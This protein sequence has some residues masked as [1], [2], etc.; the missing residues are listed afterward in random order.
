MEKALSHRFYIDSYIERCDEKTLAIAWRLGYRVVSC[1][2][3]S[4]ENR[5]D[6]DRLPVVIR[7]RVISTSSVNEL[8]DLLRSVNSKHEFITIEPLSIEAARWCVHDT[9]VDSILLSSKNIH[10][11]DKKQLNVAKYYSKPIEIPMKELL[12][13]LSM[14]AI[15][16]RRLSLYI[17]H[18]AP[19]IFSSKASHWHELYH[20]LSLVKILSTLFD[21]PSRLVL[22]S[23]TDAPRIILSTKEM[24]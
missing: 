3:A 15:L 9:R 7:K 23:I 20:P 19:I 12:S 13:I 24:K 14:R 8:K 16:Y 2:E 10:L 17:G 21:I 11:F 1:L 6:R 5:S 4:S 18:K 22:L